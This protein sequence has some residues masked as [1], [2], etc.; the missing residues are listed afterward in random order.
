MTENKRWISG[1]WILDQGIQPF[2]LIQAVNSCEL[3]AY[4][5]LTGERVN[6]PQTPEE[7]TLWE[8][9]WQEWESQQTEGEQESNSIIKFLSWVEW[10]KKCHSREWL[11]ENLPH[12]FNDKSID[13]FDE[14]E[15]EMIFSDE[16]RLK[17]VLTYVFKRKDADLFISGLLEQDSP[18]DSPP[19][20]P[21]S[22][23]PEPGASAGPVV[24]SGPSVAPQSASKVRARNAYLWRY[25]DCY[26]LLEVACKLGLKGVHENMRYQAFKNTSARKKAEE[27]IKQGRAATPKSQ[28][29]EKDPHRELG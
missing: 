18:P 1:Q 13:N 9:L 4:D 21:A 2:E 24:E 17:E 5:P 26:T 11:T 7:K 8:T 23:K 3:P 27:L 28:R 16:S 10:L 14:D 15:I 20:V 22:P 12:M 25:R 29:P 6:N 19:A